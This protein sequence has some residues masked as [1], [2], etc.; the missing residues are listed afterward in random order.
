MS[1]YWRT[2]GVVYL[3]AVAVLAGLQ[4]SGVGASRDLPLTAVGVLTTAVIAIGIR[5]HRPASRAVW[6]LLGVSVPLF[7]FGGALFGVLGKTLERH[8]ALG[9]VPMGVILLSY[10]CNLGAGALVARN[11]SRSADRVAQLDTGMVVVGVAGSM[12][13]LVLG[14]TFASLDG[15]VVLTV[16]AALTA[17]LATV[18]AAIVLRVLFMAERRSPA[19]RLLAISLLSALAADLGLER[20]SGHVGVLTASTSPAIGVGWLLSSATVG[21]AALDPSMARLTE[22]AAPI[23]QGKLGVGR[24][25]MLAAF[26]LAVPAVAS[27]QSLTGSR[28]TVSDLMVPMVLMVAL[29]MVRLNLLVRSRDTA[30]EEVQLR[31]RRFRRLV[32]NLTDHIVVIAPTGEVIYVSPS[33]ERELGFPLLELGSRPSLDF[34]HPAD[35]EVAMRAA[36]SAL[37]RPEATIRVE[38]R[39]HNSDGDERLFETAMTNLIDDPAVGGLLLVF[40]DITDR[41]HY[42]NALQHQAHHDT[43]TG[44]PNRSVASERIAA[45]LSDTGTDVHP[46]VLFIDLDNFKSVNDSLGHAAGDELLRQAAQRLSSVTRDADTVARMGGDEFLVLLD[47]VTADPHSVA[48]RIRV[49]LGRPFDIG[50]RQIMITCSVGVAIA[51]Q[52]RSA[53]LVRDAD[54]ALYHAKASGRDQAAVFSMDMH[55]SAQERLDLELDLR[56]ALESGQL[57]LDYQPLVVLDTMQV[58]GVEALI[59]WA[60]PTRGVIPPAVFIPIAEQTGLIH[61]FGQWV[62]H[63]AC[64]DAVQWQM[65]GQTVP[66]S[67][68]VSARQLESEAIVEHVKSALAHS[69]LPASALVLEMTESELMAHPESAVNRLRS[70]KDLGIMVAIDDFGTGYSSLSVLREFPIDVLK[71]DRSFVSRA[72]QSSESEAVI[73]ALIQLARALRLEVVAEGVE[74]VEELD[75]L[76]RQQCNRA[77]GYLFS[78][79]VDAATVSQVVG[80]LLMR[81]R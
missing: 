73:H 49:A 12:W 32:E 53:D 33:I 54:I 52:T 26:L 34:L 14:P 76:R 78:R 10:C 7:T 43:L 31:E 50:G 13:M 40:H 20:M 37:E 36:T 77:Q 80:E 60:H 9:A 19:L 65:D 46:A 42:E 72:D 25:F 44:L 70:L 8:P 15:P 38:V 47:G 11:V 75:V 2:I 48:E 41:A 3:G 29:V 23:V 56:F 62:L 57:Y 45:V 24:S 61:S 22:R 4:L 18:L 27:Y 6:V 16:G 28:L 68:N 39:I 63:T 69:G 59:R 5:A 66:V 58:S 64:A 67:V 74:R 21:L 35:V 71:I 79:P 1:K 81:A 51:G 17:L 55:G 30:Q